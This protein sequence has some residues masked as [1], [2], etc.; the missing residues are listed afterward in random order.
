VK[1]RPRA[2]AAALG[3]ALAVTLA[4]CFGVQAQSSGGGM[5]AAS[6]GHGSISL[7]WFPAV[8][9]M[10]AG[11]WRLSEIS[12][13]GRR[14]VAARIEMGNASA[15]AKLSSDDAQSIKEFPVKAAQA[16]TSRDTADLYA[17]LG[18]K[19]F[20]DPAYA[21]AAGLSYRIAGAASGDRRYEVLGLSAGGVPSGPVLR[22]ATVNPAV[23]TQLPATP[24]RVR[25]VSTV[26]GVIVYWTAPPPSRE[27]PV[28][29]YAIERDGGGQR[30]VRLTNKPLVLGTGMRQPQFVDVY[31]PG[32]TQLTYRV[33]SIDPFGR[34]SAPASASFLAVDMKAIA[35]VMV[36]AT[37]GRNETTLHWQPRENPHTAGYVVERANLYEGPYVP[38]T[39]RPLGPRTGSFTDSSLRGG[40]VYYYRVLAVSPQGDL[41]PPSIAVASQPKDVAAPAQVIG[42][43]AS[44]GTSRVHLTWRPSFAP[45]AGYF[46]ERRTGSESHW[47]TLNARLTPAPFYDDYY[48]LGTYGTLAY[49][50]VAV[51]WDNKQAPPSDP[52]SVTLADT[53]PPAAPYIRSVSGRNGTVTISLAAAA[54][55]SKTAY[56]LALRSGASYRVGVVIG[57]PIPAGLHTF[58]DRNVQPGQDYWYRFV[59]V[60]R[61]GSR[62]QLT[63]PIVVHVGSA[64][65]PSPLAPKAAY[66][67]SPF[68][69][70]QIT[71]GRIPGGLE[72]LVQ[73]RTGGKGPWVLVAGPMPL[74]TRAI[75]ANPPAHSRVAYRI[76]YQASNGARSTPS[77]SAPV[78]VP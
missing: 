47:E 6:D 14:V 9:E 10:P 16:R 19:A 59:A 23:A 73:R 56:F 34:R 62:S 36:S 7:V 1:R 38:L 44:A 35:P 26:N 78:S 51:G 42:L 68:G 4:T 12:G 48:G 43:R 58:V 52:V 50:I 67:S 30:N 54:P 49:R 66:S 29:A 18:I 72:V 70:V 21:A 31:A 74:G 77:A 64:A 5:L 57:D 32:D 24:T 60:D 22:S 76:V 28:M 71:F 8:G 3:F 25:G 46:I 69:H 53:T 11:G 20:T 37:S 17:V 40:T 63:M 2:L 55:A 61:N 27:V 15:L 75:D 65:L 33:Y 41:G 39:L 13:G 45:I